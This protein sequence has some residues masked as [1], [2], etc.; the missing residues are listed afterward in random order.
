MLKMTMLMILGA[1]VKVN[2]SSVPTTALIAIIRIRQRFALSV[3]VDTAWI[4]KAS[5][6]SAQIL[7][8]LSA[9]TKTRANIAIPDTS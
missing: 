5:A 2:V 9:A 7:I 1:M 4:R 6:S 8:V 3:I